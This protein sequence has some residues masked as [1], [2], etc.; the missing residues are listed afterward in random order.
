[1]SW[2]DGEEPPRADAG[3]HRGT[4]DADRPP[5]IRWRVGRRAAV[6]AVLALALLGGAVALRSASA[7][8]T[9]P[10]VDL[11]EPRA[12]ASASAPAGASDGSTG[13]AADGGG[14]E[15]AANAQ[16]EVVV[17]VVGQVVAPGVV[18]LPAGSRVTDALDAAGGALPEAD[19]SGLNLAA[20]LTDGVQVRVP[21]PGEPVEAVPAVDAGGGTAVEGAG[22]GDGLLDVN[23]ATVMQLDALPGIGPVLAERIVQWRTEHG[24]FGSVDDLEQVSGIGPA[25]LEKLRDRV[26]V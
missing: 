4:D 22:T 17:H 6:G 24:R 8:P 9:G 5:G 7:A 16:P 1:M 19:L 25:V 14:T 10:A 2:Y 20:V 3:R 23:A 18:T 15:G 26:R 12:S 21:L 13:S 11:G